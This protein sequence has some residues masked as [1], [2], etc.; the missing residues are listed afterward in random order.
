MGFR[1]NRSHWDGRK[2]HEEFAAKDFRAL[3]RMV[4]RPE[5]TGMFTRP[6][7]ERL[8]LRSALRDG[9]IFTQL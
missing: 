8:A 2:L 1:L 7:A 9:E 4:V 6:E 5:V 3:V